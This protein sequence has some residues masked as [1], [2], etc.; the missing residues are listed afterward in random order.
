M[1]N[2]RSVLLIAT[3]IVFSVVSSAGAGSGSDL[4]VVIDTLEQGYNALLDIQADF[5]QRTAIASM[6]REERGAGELF[7]KKPAG[8]AAKFRFNYVKPRQQIVSNGKSVWY[9][10]P[11]NKQVM[12]SDVAAVFEGGNGVALNYL[13]G[14]GHVSR[15]FTI[16]FAG[17]GRDKKG[18]YVLELVPN[19]QNQVLVKLQLTVSAQAVEA[20]RETG[21][22][23]VPF[24]I[25]S[26]VVYDSLGNRTTIEFSK[27][28]VN[29]GIGNERFAFKIPAGVEVIKPR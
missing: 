7:I 20:F 9:Y 8:A 4:K 27:I 5:S 17:T 1:K 16:S 24:P 23:Q 29:R 21:K 2:F 13:T 6:K 12:V 3:F 22:A 10:L 15:D 25:L 18:N 19:K 14:M 28:K 11:D 26:S